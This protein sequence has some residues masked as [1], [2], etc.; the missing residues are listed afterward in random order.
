MSLSEFFRKVSERSTIV[1][2]A[3]MAGAQFEYDEKGTT[4][5]YFLISFYGLI[6][7]PLSYYV[8]NNTKI[9]GENF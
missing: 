4:F 2:E 6:L 7:V 9:T 5:Y 8:W 1:Q 3:K